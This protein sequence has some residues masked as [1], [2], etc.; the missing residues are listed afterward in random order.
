MKINVNVCSHEAVRSVKSCNNL[1]QMNFRKSL[2][3]ILITLL[4]ITACGKKGP[5]KYPGEQKR[6][7]FYD[8]T[9]ENE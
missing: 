8:V 6:P 1:G 4:T 9:D 7:R 2:C 3:V 5:L